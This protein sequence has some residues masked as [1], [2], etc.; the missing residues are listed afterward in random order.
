M[1]YIS[2]NVALPLTD[3]VLFNIVVLV[4]VN[5]PWTAVFPDVVKL[6]RLVAPVIPNVPPIVAFPLI[7]RPLKL[8]APVTSNVPPIK[9][10]PLKEADPSSNLIQAVVVLVGSPP[11]NSIVSPSVAS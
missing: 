10:F 11:T 5:V 8:V 2:L 9:V 1:S 6:L 3:N 4:T 7:L